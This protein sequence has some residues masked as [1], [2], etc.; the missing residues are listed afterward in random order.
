MKEL[1]L[2]SASPRRKELL[3]EAGYAFEIVKTDADENIDVC[4][5]TLLVCELA[6]IKAIAAAKNIKKDCYVIGADTVVCIG[7]RIL[8][9]PKTKRQA[10]LML[11]LLSGR[12]HQ[13]Y[14]GVCVFDNKNARMISKFERSDVTFCNLSNVQIRNYVLSGEPMDKAGSYAIQENG[15]V[16]VKEFS[17]NMDNIIGLPM[18]TLKDIFFELENDL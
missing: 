3:K 18:T 5:P 17:G 4:D 1:V 8:G 6:A 14:T 9:K 15:R 10:R 11:K 13:V 7:E 2:A 12:K 16:F